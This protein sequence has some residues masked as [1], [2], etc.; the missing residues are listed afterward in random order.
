MSSTLK[1]VKFYWEAGLFENQEDAM[2][3]LEDLRLLVKNLHRQCDLGLKIRPGGSV[4]NTP[5][6]CYVSDLMIGNNCVLVHTNDRKST[7]LGYN[8]FNFMSTGSRAFNEQNEAWMQNL[9]AKSTLISRTAEKIR[10]RFFKTLEKQIDDLQ[11]F[12]NEN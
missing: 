3:I 9:M 10:N 5:F 6:H 12:I 1:Q 4:S 11:K 2:S 7:Y 8:T